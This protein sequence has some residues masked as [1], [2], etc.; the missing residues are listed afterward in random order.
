MKIFEQMKTRHGDDSVIEEPLTDRGQIVETSSNDTQQMT[1][2]P[3]IDKSY[4]R[5]NA[6]HLTFKD[7]QML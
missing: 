4:F 7:K 3:Q 2:P 1:D 5:D 6:S